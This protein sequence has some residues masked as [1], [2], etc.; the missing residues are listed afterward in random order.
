[1][2]QTSHEDFSWRFGGPTRF[3][4]QKLV[5]IYGIQYLYNDVRNRGIRDSGLRNK[6]LNTYLRRYLRSTASSLLDPDPRKRIRGDMKV[7][8]VGATHFYAAVHTWAQ[9]EWSSSMYVHKHG[10]QLF[11]VRGRIIGLG[12]PGLHSIRKGDLVVQLDR[13]KQFCALRRQLDDS[14][15]FRG[16]VIV[17]NG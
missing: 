8:D 6:Y 4:G 7:S 5:D 14:Y 15:T 11:M 13:R 2:N 3:P 17:E 16:A 9:H 12:P 1:M 10:R